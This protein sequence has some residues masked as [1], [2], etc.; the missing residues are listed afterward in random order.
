MKYLLIAS[1]VV[2]SSAP[3]LS[4]EEAVRVLRASQSSAD[5]T[6]ARAVVV[7][8]GPTS[9]A[10]PSRSGDG[11]FGPFPKFAPTPPSVIRFRIPRRT[12]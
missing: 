8:D 5:R 7:H 6:D 2:Q 3:P 11:P 9:I 10:I 4:P 1:F 12:P